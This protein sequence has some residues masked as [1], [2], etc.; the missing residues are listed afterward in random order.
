MGFDIIYC[1][2]LHFGRNTH[3]VGTNVR[4]ESGCAFPCDFDAFVKLLRD[5]HRLRRGERQ[6]CGSV[7]LQC[8]RR[9]RG[10]RAVFRDG[11][12]CAVNGEFCAFR[13]VDYLFG[14]VLVMNFP[15]FAVYIDESAFEHVL[16]GLRILLLRQKG[17]YRPVFFGDEVSYFSF[18]V[19]NHFERGGLYASGG[20]ALFNALPE[21]WRDFVTDKSVKNAPCLL[22][23]DKVNIEFSGVFDCVIDRF[24]ADFVENDAVFAVGDFQTVFKVPTYCFSFAVRV[25]CEIHDVV[26][27]ERGFKSSDGFFLFGV[28]FV[29]GLE[30]VFDVDAQRFLRKVADVTARC[31]YRVPLSQIFLDCF[32]L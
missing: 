30:S 2:C 23:V 32:R 28:D 20:T 11:S 17:V 18:A 16:F 25:G 22:A 15:L 19:D 3:A 21:N 29:F 13:G 31:E 26:L 10:C 24:F 12:F 5:L 27:F 14:V 8:G 6:F 4:Y 7:L 1:V 9:K